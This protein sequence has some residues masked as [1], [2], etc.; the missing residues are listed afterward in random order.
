MDI[1]EGAIY[2]VVDKALECTEAVIDGQR[3]LTCVGPKAQETTNEITVCNPSCST[4]PD[5][6]GAE[7][8]CAS[9]YTLASDGQCNY[10]PIVREAGVAGCPAGYVLLEGNGQKSCALGPGADGN[11]PTGL[12]LDSL[13]GA[14]MPAAG[15]SQIPY[16]IND[17]GLAS[18]TYQGCA[19]GYAYDANFQCCQA[20]T[21]GTYPGCAPGSAFNADL[22]ACSP[23]DLRLSGPGCVTVS[24]NILKCSEPVDICSKITSEIRCIKNSYACF[25]NERDGICQ[26]K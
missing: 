22:G 19:S 24:M 9:G 18:Q 17:P 26:L 3:R 4:S 25:W 2:E 13:V 10:T 21:G 6:T 16:G 8:A 1:P 12:Y 11:C 5:I 7:P 23:N 14:C 20:Q 15:Q